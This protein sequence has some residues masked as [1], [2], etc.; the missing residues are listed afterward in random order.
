M[1]YDGHRLSAGNTAFDYARLHV[2]LLCA[3]VYSLKKKTER[4]TDKMENTA[5]R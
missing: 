4:Q 5:R 2:A 1:T 3:P